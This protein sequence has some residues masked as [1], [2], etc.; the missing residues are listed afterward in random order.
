MKNKRRNIFRLVFISAGA[1]LLYWAY[2][3]NQ[4]KID[5]DRCWARVVGRVTSGANL[6]EVMSVEIAQ[7]QELVEESLVARVKILSVLRELSGDADAPISS[8]NLQTL[9]AGTVGYLD[10]RARLYEVAKRYECAIASPAFLL[11]RHGIDPLLKT[12]AVLL[13]LAAALTL[14]DNWILALA[15]LE[16]E[17]RIRRILNDPDS[18]Y[19]IDADNL[20][21]IALNANSL[22]VRTRIRRAIAYFEGER[23]KSDKA[24]EDDGDRELQYLNLLIAG[25]PSYAMVRERR[26][27]TFLVSQLDSVGKISSDFLA[28]LQKDGMNLLSKFFGNAVGIVETRTGKLY[29]DRAVA[30]SLR[31]TL[32]P[33]DILLEKTPFRLTDKFIPGHFGHAAI[34][35][36]S[37]KDL[38]AAGIWDHPLVVPHREAIA[39][40]DGG[41]VLEALR[42]G[43]QLT[44]LDHFLN[45]DDLAVLRLAALA[46][47]SDGEIDRQLREDSLLM[48][49]RQ[50]GKD[51]DFNFDVDT[52]EK[53]VCSELIYVSFPIVD[54]AT[55]KVMGRFTISPDNIAQLA[56]GG[57]KL[58][59]ITLYHDGK[60][61][62][63]D[64][65]GAKL[66]E[67]LGA[68]VAG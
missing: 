43:V 60:K 55:E 29:G 19:G 62:A 35:L 52:T 65:A 24:G 31:S 21:T 68:A 63:D 40:S 1:F 53:I 45:V 11:K 25:S 5:H 32:Q 47:G 58:K 51:Y 33:L 67:L 10:L 59:L 64:R 42:G 7:F 22:A 26:A 46:P 27:G 3:F 39:A 48:A 9:K 49:F 16:G 34:W 38:V 4:L 17:P 37:R 14:N 28:E 18:G 61:I 20:K 36:G 2:S 57:E 13:S 30:D 15:A 54:W 50:V 12:K 56:V 23:K 41:V 66:A 8:R 44:R 6:E